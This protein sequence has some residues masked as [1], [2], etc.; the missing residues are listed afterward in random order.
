MANDK[1][2]WDNRTEWTEY[3]NFLGCKHRMC[4]CVFMFVHVYC[5][6]LNKK[7]YDTKWQWQRI[8]NTK[9]NMDGWA[10]EH[11]IKWE[12]HLNARRTIQ[13][14]VHT[15]DIAFKDIMGNFY[16]RKNSTRKTSSFFPSFFSLLSFVICLRAL[17][18]QSLLS[19]WAWLSW[20]TKLLLLLLHI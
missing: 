9:L 7:W 18:W 1:K 20:S 11:R 5:D 16:D 2:K 12:F 15:I 13:W 10:N 19:C 6:S 4:V 3:Y 17:L 8:N 14:N